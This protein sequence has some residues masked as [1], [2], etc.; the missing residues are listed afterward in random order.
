M[1]C[2]VVYVIHPLQMLFVIYWLSLW[3]YGKSFQTFC[4]RI[5]S[6]EVNKMDLKM[7]SRQSC[8]DQW[9]IYCREEIKV[10]T[11]YTLSCESWKPGWLYIYI[12]MLI[13]NYCWWEYLDT[14]YVRVEL[15][16][17]YG[18]LY[19]SDVKPQNVVA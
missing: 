16:M 14:V 17:K 5:L 10:K 19:W 3:N 7:M 6:A 8:F 12:Y 15:L 13:D 9:L 2:S 18:M 11:M 4:Y 1:N